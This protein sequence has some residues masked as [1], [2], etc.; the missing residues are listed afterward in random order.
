MVLDLNQDGD[1]FTNFACQSLP[2]ANSLC[3]HLTTLQETSSTNNNGMQTFEL[4]TSSD[5]HA[6]RI[7]GTAAEQGLIPSDNI[8]IS[9][10]SYVKRTEKLMEKFSIICR[11]LITSLVYNLN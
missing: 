3:K 5:F 8:T 2:T 10:I 1:V 4:R 6:D 9:R 11:I 7:V